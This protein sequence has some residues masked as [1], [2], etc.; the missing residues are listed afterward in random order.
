MPHLYNPYFRLAP[1][2]DL[3]IWALTILFYY[4]R[5]EISVKQQ[6]IIMPSNYER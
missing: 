6:T 1:R 2:F 5:N 3:F 4:F